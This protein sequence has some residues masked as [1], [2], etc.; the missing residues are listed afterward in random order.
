[1]RMSCST[2]QIFQCKFALIL[3]KFSCDM[4]MSISGQF[5]VRIALEFGFGLRC[6]SILPCDLHCI[7]L[8]VVCVL[9]VCCVRVCVCVFVGVVCSLCVPLCPR[10][11]GG[12][13]VCVFWLCCMIGR[14]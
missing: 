13:S 1:M 5:S 8:S 7:L 2:G 12:L 9:C 3:T 14:Q 6:N 4:F 10:V 11:C